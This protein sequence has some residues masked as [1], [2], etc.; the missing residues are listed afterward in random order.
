MSGYLQHTPIEIINLI[1]SNTP[2]RYLKL[3]M[4]TSRFFAKITTGYIKARPKFIIG[5]IDTFE[6]LFQINPTADF[7]KIC[8]N[9]ISAAM[10]LQIQEKQLVNLILAALII[11]SKCAFMEIIK[12]RTRLYVVDIYYENRLTLE[13]QFSIPFIDWT[14]IPIMFPWGFTDVVP[15]YRYKKI[16][17]TTILNADR[18]CWQIIIS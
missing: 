15:F 5:T 14:N 4:Q 3:F 16:M 2:D 10:G 1:L 7:L 9:E 8:S 6:N 12:K 11:Q 17:C 13:K 18:Y